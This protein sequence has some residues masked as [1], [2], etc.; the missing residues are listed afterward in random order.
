MGGKQKVR[1]SFDRDNSLESLNKT[2][3]NQIRAGTGTL[4]QTRYEYYVRE[5][6]RSQG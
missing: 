4:R 1:Y 2:I 3:K 6:Y 5:F